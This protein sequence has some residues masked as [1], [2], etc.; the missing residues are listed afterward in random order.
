MKVHAQP[1]M[2]NWNYLYRFS[3]FLFLR[4]KKKDLKH[5]QTFDKYL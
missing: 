5:I 4:N 2:T 3:D 1:N